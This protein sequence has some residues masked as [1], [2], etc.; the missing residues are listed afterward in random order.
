MQA[1]LKALHRDPW[2]EIPAGYLMDLY[3]K[4]RDDARVSWR[5][6][7]EVITSWRNVIK[8]VTS[9]HGDHTASCLK[10]LSL[11]FKLLVI[12]HTLNL[13]AQSTKPASS[14]FIFT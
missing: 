5:F 8:I 6:A 14:R 9:R 7:Q 13:M 1:I 12:E 2:T 10:E 11:T 4:R 3:F